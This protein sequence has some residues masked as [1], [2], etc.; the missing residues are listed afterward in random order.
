MEDVPVHHWQI[1][2]TLALVAL[3]TAAAGFV[4]RQRYRDLFATL[5]AEATLFLVLNV[6][7]VLRDS[8]EIRGHIGYESSPTPLRAT[9]AGLLIRLVL[10]LALAW[11]IR[12][13]RSVMAQPSAV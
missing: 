4:I 13:R 2:A 10:L 1:W 12:Q 9:A 5:V 7:Y 8:V 6:I 3:L 11:M